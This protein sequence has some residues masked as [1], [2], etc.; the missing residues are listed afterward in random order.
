MKKDDESVLPPSKKSRSKGVY[1]LS[2]D[3]WAAIRLWPG[4][5]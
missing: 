2:V 4:H 1:P 5:R 3:E